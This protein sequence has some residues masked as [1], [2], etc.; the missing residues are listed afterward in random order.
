METSSQ[1]KLLWGDSEK[2]LS[3]P[4]LDPLTTLNLLPLTP[5]APNASGGHAP[6]VP[7]CLGIFFR[8]TEICLLLCWRFQKWGKAEMNL[9]TQC[10]ERSSLAVPAQGRWLKSC[11]DEQRK[12][13]PTNFTPVMVNLDYLLARI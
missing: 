10:E 1:R 5:R 4:S 12:T 11:G 9:L 2:G 8:V 6:H 13:L 7:D 3:S